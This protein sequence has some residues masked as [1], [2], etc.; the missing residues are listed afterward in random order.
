MDILLSNRKKEGGYFWTEANGIYFRGY[1]QLEDGTVYREGSAIKFFQNINTFNEFIELL[2]KVDGRFA[3]ILNRKGIIWAA[4]D[5]ERTM[6]LYYTSD[7]KL[8]SDDAEELRKSKGIN[9]LNIN[10]M[11]C[12][13]MYGTAYIAYD[14]T[15]YEEIK[16][17]DFREAIEI[18]NNILKKEKYYI[19][20][21]E[22][23]NI[24]RSGA[25]KQL[26]VVTD[27]VM[28]RTKKVLNG[29]T[30][31]LS[32]SGGYDSRFVACSLKKNG[33]DN[34]ICYAYGDQ[35]SFEIQQSKIV[36][37]AL[38]YKW[39]YVEYKDDDIKNL[40]RGE[41]AD[42]FEYCKEHDFVI[43]IQNYIAVKRLK[44]QGYIPEDAVFITGLGNDT[45][46]GHYVPSKKVA[47]EFGLNEKGL[48]DFAV[49]DRFSRFNISDKAK[50]FF[51]NEILENAKITHMKVFDYQS[52]VTAWD[53]IN[54]G[55]GHSRW[56]PKMN[57]VHEYFGHEWLLPC[58]DKELLEF[59]RGIPVEMRINHNLFEEYMIS[60]L[61][62]EFGIG[63]KKIV[64]ENAKTPA[65]QKLKR[66]LGGLA[67]RLFYPLGIPI[68]RKADVN[69][70]APLE[71]ELYRKIKQKKAVKAERAG[72][73]L[74]LTIYVMEQ[75][76]GTEWYKKI[77]GYFQ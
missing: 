53:D 9:H 45:P 39:L 48:A 76:Y 31:V 11:R 52:F 40:V 5:I 73:L 46:V 75:R 72:I 63:T 77:Q 69:N 19:S 18:N 62:K 12:L 37:D 68:K 28:Q 27:R 55:Y 25:M 26:S 56:Y 41:D 3:V 21:S 47:E 10:S 34:V 6:P 74:L 22:I 71:V 23:A 30:V 70:F 15:I 50:D 35:N 59:W 16:Q 58:F 66:V 60:D 7:L 36:A 2:K 1:I 29:R 44:K 64:E 49:S 17:I 57:K 24:S 38:G 54:I 42:F 33:I 65:G 20:Q 61:G 4:V 43:Y 8:I 51:A 13:E 32:L 14:N 67:V